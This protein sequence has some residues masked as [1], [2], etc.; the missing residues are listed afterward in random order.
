[1]SSKNNVPTA[2]DSVSEI[3]SLLNVSKPV[4]PLVSVIDLSEIDLVVMAQHASICY[5][6]YSI[7]LKKN[8][9]GKIRYGQQY[10]DFNEGIMSFY[11]PRQVVAVSGGNTAKLE[12]WLLIIHPDFL[13][14]YQLAAKIK[15]YGF[16]SYAVNEA[17]HLSEKEENIIA[18]GMKNIKAEIEVSTDN[19]TRDVVISHIDLILSYCN[20]FYNRQFITRQVASMDILSRLEKILTSYFESGSVKE[21]G[22]PSV[23][24]VADRLNISPGYL[25]DMLRFHTGRSTQ[26]HIHD[27]LIEK[28]KEL[29]TTS[30]LSVAEIAFQLGFE[31]PQ[32]FN[33]L[34]RS[35]TNQSPLEF[36]QSFN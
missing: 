23:Q 20:R 10:Y 7:Y 9:D 28:A 8:F 4:H 25:G 2:I 16:F 11:G 22:L 15:E 30:K 24:Y 17:L 6:F 27:A 13:Q 29:L 26:Q 34:F 32:S 12:G 19:F 3:H 31:Y 1:M 5:N 35:K 18:E 21:M 36:R 14:G 33:K